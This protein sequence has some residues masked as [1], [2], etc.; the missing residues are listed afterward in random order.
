MFRKPVETTF[1]DFDRVEEMIC[2]L[3]M[4]ESMDGYIPNMEKLE[5]ESKDREGFVLF[6]IWL[7]TAMKN[8]GMTQAAA[9]ANRRL[10]ELLVL[11]GE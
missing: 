4:P 8:A 3:D 2:T 6:L 7:T 11:D 9:P 5:K 1:T 10:R